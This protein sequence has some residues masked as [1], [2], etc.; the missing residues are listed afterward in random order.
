MALGAGAVGSWLIARWFDHRHW[1]DLPVRLGV[2]DLTDS[3]LA[4]VLNQLRSGGVAAELDN[5]V[6][7]YTGKRHAWIRT[8]QRYLAAVKQAVQSAHN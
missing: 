4:G 3:Q 8:T 7:A 2:D 6:D 5:E 1:L